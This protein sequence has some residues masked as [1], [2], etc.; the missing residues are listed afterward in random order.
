MYQIAPP[1]KLNFSQPEEWLKWSR[2][3]ECLT[4]K[5]ETS[6]INTL[7]YAMGDEADDILTS[8][9]LMEAQ[10]RKYDIVMQMFE[11]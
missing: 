3:F 2:R 11:V 8:L 7:I 1:E 6:Q 10:K 5:E 4:V 9:K